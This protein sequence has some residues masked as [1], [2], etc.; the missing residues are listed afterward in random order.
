MEN[1]IKIT[2]ARHAW[3]EKAGFTID[4]PRG[5]PEY[6][7]LHFF[8]SVQILVNGETLPLS[9]SCKPAFFELL[10]HRSIRLK[11]NVE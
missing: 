3:P 9:D 2:R 5:L 10:S 4:R 11:T 1:Q 6:T 7:F 8:E